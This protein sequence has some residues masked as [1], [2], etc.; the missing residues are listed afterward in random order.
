[1]PTPSYCSHAILQKPNA[2]IFEAWLGG[3]REEP[4]TITKKGPRKQYWSIFGAS[5]WGTTGSAQNS[6]IKSCQEAVVNHFQVLAE[7]ET[8]GRTQIHHKKAPRKQFWEIFGFWPRNPR[9]RPKRYNAMWT[10]NKMA[11]L[12]DRSY[13][14]IWKTTTKWRLLATKA[15]ARHVNLQQIGDS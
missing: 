3:P 6:H 12:S 9:N 8:S 13:T 1:M 14:M 5:L 15:I 11:T 10:Y 2:A 4:E 7:G